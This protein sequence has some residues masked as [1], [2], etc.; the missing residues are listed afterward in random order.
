MRPQSQSEY[1]KLLLG[2]LSVDCQNT[3]KSLEDELIWAT[4]AACMLSL[5]PNI[6]FIFTSIRIQQVFQLIEQEGHSER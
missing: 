2:D 6:C 3:R 4:C 1:F 5:P